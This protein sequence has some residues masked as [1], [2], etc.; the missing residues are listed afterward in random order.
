M[1]YHAQFEHWIAVPLEKVFAFFA[2]PMN[3]PGIMPTWLE[4]RFEEMVVAPPTGAPAYFAG[5]GTKFVASYRAIPFFSSRIRS[6]V[7][8]VG[9]AMYEF[10]SDVQIKGP[11]R[12][13]Q[14]RHEFAAETRGGTPGTRLRDRIEYELAGE[15]LG[16]IVNAL[17]IAPQMRR[18]FAYRQLA[19]ERI[20]G[21][22]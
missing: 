7:Q 18:T 16:R 21:A 11:F 5:V 17:F 4:M 6:E 12:S 3:L 22:R 2:D 14:H 9:F 20:L 1:S 8:I 13:W 10:F 19:V 15:P